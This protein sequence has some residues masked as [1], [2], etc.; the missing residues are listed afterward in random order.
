MQGISFSSG[1][2]KGVEVRVQIC[3]GL[4]KSAWKRDKDFGRDFRPRFGESTKIE[5]IWECEVDQDWVVDQEWEVDL[6]LGCR[7]D[8]V[9][10]LVAIEAGSRTRTRTRTGK[11]VG[12]IPAGRPWKSNWDW[13]VNL[14][15]A[16]RLRGRKSTPN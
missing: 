9:V 8:L 12:L 16:G 10:D 11:E 3:Q 13:L 7:L 2:Q 4:G 15:L 14:R 1:R 6:G 5:S